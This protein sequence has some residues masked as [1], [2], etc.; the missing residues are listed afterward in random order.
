MPPKPLQNPSPGF[1][2][3]TRHWWEGCA[4]GELWLQRCGACGTLRH[5][6]RALCPKCLS[7]ETEYVQASGR[8]TVH[9]FTVTHQNHAPAF[10]AACPYV[11]AYVELEEGPRVL[12]NI[13]G[14]EPGDVRIG[15]PVVV[16]FGEP[17]GEI[18][19]PRFRP[20]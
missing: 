19:V 20:A 6:P 11:L 5:R 15:L 16:D 18:A 10:R 12:T 14:C 2:W 4:R 9:T 7:D 17:D 3:E 1:D 8:G 13:V